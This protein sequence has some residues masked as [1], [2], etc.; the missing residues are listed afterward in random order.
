[1]TLTRTYVLG[2]ERGFAGVKLRDIAS[3]V[4]RLRHALNIPERCAKEA[5][6][7]IEVAIRG[8]STFVAQPEALAAVVLFYGCR[9]AG[10]LL[11]LKYFTSHIA[12]EKS[13]IKRVV[14]DFSK[15]APLQYE[16]AILNAAKRVGL[17]ADVVLELWKKYRRRLVGKKPRAVAAVLAYLA[18]GGTDPISVISEVMRVSPTAVREALAQLKQSQP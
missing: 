10:V 2:T 6:H 4:A 9:Q 13:A 8:K 17:S 7:L 3:E 16:R 11:P 12:V 18:K 1:M 14:W 15:L 5:L